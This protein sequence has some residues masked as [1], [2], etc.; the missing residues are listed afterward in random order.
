MDVT[1]RGDEAAQYAGPA[2]VI[3]VPAGEEP[4]DKAS[5]AV[6]AALDGLLTQLR[7][8]GEI[9][10]KRGTTTVLHTLGRLPA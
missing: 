5:A 10:G 7:V 6:D 3:G 8:G 9:T 4:L 1:V 2:L